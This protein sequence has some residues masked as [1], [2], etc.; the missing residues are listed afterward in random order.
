MNQLNPLA[1]PYLSDNGTMHADAE[2]SDSTT[3][4]GTGSSTELEFKFKDYVAACPTILGGAPLKGGGTSVFFAIMVAYRGIPSNRIPSVN[5][6]D[7]DSLKILASY[8]LVVS[9]ELGGIYTYLDNNNSVVA[10]DGSRTLK[11]IQGVYSQEEYSLSLT[12]EVDL[13]PYIN[14]GDSAAGLVPDWQGNTWYATVEG[15]VGFINA[16]TEK[17][18]VLKL[19]KFNQSSESVKNTISSC[20]EGVVVATTY[21]IYFLKIVDELISL[22]W[23]KP[24]D[25]GVG[26]K[27]GMLSW[28]TGTSPTF[29]GPDKGYEYVT[30]VDNHYGDDPEGDGNYSNLC[31]YRTSDGLE[32]PK[33]PINTSAKGE[34]NSA[35]E[36]SVVAFGNSLFVTNTYGYDYPSSI[37]DPKDSIPKSADFVGGLMRFDFDGENLLQK[38][39]KSDL[40]V[41]SVPR[42]AVNE[43]KLYTFSL[44]KLTNPTKD[45]NNLYYSVLDSET[46]DLIVNMRY[47]SLVGNLKQPM[48]MV[49]VIYNNAVY[50]GTINGI[51]KVSCK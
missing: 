10:I 43:N 3:Q 6:I 35:S 29:F 25:I 33:Q 39:V 32:Y 20:P 17:G 22:V 34:G 30:I 38:W 45:G 13:S 9:S 47:S 2:S 24:Y 36:A 51:I 48:G 4:V 27:P 18:D 7:T 23:Y 8:D 15:Y 31:V 1:N 28:G 11:F 14:E 50:Q 46:G 19:N 37:V 16:E 21:G 49:I 40:F 42:L 44:G 41:A 26:R 12:K 5:L